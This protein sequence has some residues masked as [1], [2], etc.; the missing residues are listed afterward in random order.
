MLDG[1]IGSSEFVAL[2]ES[3]GIKPY[4]LSAAARVINSGET[5]LSDSTP[6]PAL[7]WLAFLI[8]S[9][10]IGFAAVR[11]LRVTNVGK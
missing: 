5:R 2:A 4:R 11:Q 3:Y 7:P 10:L 6:I 9:G 1:F 8:L